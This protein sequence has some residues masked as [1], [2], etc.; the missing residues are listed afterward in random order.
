MKQVKILSEECKKKFP[1]RP[2]DEIDFGLGWRAA[3]KILLENTDGS[4]G[5]RK[6][7][8]METIKEELQ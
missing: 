4:C 2:P 7:I 1:N 6:C 5:V 8:P 3:F